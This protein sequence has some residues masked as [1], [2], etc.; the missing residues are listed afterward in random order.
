MFFESF[1]HFLQESN[2]A[3]DSKPNISEDKLQYYYQ[4]TSGGILNLIESWMC[5]DMEESDEEM[6]TTLR[7]IKEAQSTKFQ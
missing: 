3:I 5:G 7:Q 6:A 2:L 1:S 4:Y